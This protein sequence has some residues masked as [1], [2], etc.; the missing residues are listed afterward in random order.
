MK[1]RILMG[2]L[3]FSLP[4]LAGELGI[5]LGGADINWK[6]GGSTSLDMFVSV[7][8]ESLST[9]SPMVKAGPSFEIGYGKK[10]I[11]TF[12]CV[13]YGVC[14]VDLTY[15]TL[16]LNGKVAVSPM[17]L[18]DI[19]GGGGVSYSRFGLDAT[20]PYT[21]NTVGTL[22]DEFGTG[23]QLFAGAQAVFGIFGVGLEYKYKKLNTDSIDS[24]SAITLNLSLRF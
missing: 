2:V 3:A 8:A 9:V 22:G 24:V 19:F 17:P 20:D 4:A 13:G 11:G 1:K 14:S 21:G 5:K 18:L 6:G 7:Y 23:F 15:T 12:Y 16:E 10:D